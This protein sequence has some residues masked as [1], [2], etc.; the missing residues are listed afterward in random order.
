M[1]HGRRITITQ[2]RQ[3]TRGAKTMPVTGGSHNDTEPQNHSC[4]ML[5]AVLCG[6]LSLYGQATSARPSGKE[7]DSSAV[8]RRVV[9]YT[10]MQRHTLCDRKQETTKTAPLG[11]DRLYLTSEYAKRQPPI[12]GNPI[13]RV[14][15]TPTSNGRHRR[16]VN[17]YYID[18]TARLTIT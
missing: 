17:Y 3:W 7:T 18:W 11:I 12:Y 10:H 13:L 9:T 6:S 14:R 16:T 1:L 4:P 2:N 5:F 8:K 15:K